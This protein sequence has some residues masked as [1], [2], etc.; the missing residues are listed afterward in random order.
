[1][2][3][4][5]LIIFFEALARN[6]AG[7]RASKK[8]DGRPG[9]IRM[10]KRLS[11]AMMGSAALIWASPAPVRAADAPAE[12]PGILEAVVITGT[13]IRAPNL[14]S[15][16]PITAVSDEEVKDQGATNIENVL[17]ELPQF[18]AGQS[19]T[20][21]NNS[22]GVAN[23]N[24]R[25]LGPTRTLVL[26]DGRR[27]GPGD[28]Q[29]A[30][31]AAADVNFIP[32]S[33]I[34]GVDVLTG[35]AS[36]VYGSD[37][38]AGVVNF[39]M[40]RDF[41]G[42]QITT[43]LNAAQHTQSG[44][45][46]PVLRAAPYPIPVAIPGNQFD[47]FV[48]DTTLLVGTNTADHRGNV[49]M[50]VE[51][52]TTSPV[53]DGSR[54]F[55][56]CA[57]S[58]NKAQTG[59][60]CNGSSNGLYGNF[61]TNDGQQL[62]L[63]PDGS[64][65][66]I[67]FAKK[68]KYSNTPSLYLQR[69]DQRASLG[70]I[71]HQQI[72]PALDVYGEVMFM[73]DKTAAQVAPGGL[74][75]GQGPTGFIQVPCNNQ[76]MS[77]AQAAVI[78]EDANGNPMPIYQAGGQPNI[79]TIL[80]PG[81]RI[82]GHPRVDNLE[83]TD[84][85]AVVGV[86]GDIDSSW[87]YDVSGTYWDSLLS[88][89]FLND[90][91]FPKVQNAINGCTAPGNPGCV[92]LNIFQYGGVTPAQVGYITTPGLKT[93]DTRET[94]IDGNV[95]GDFGA[96]G[97]TSPGAKNP[98]ATSFGATYRHDQLNFLPDNELQTNDLIGQGA[99]YP[100][101]SGAESVKEEYAELRVSLIEDKP[102][103]EAMD[104]DLAYRHSGYTVGGS[105]SGFSTN[106]FKIA[107]DY[108]PTSDIRFRASFNRAARAPN[109]YELFLPQTLNN[110]AGYDDPCS[111][112]AP[113]ATL[114]ACAKTGV[115]AAQYGNI[116]ACPS[117]NCDALS[118]GNSALKP[119]KADTYSFG[120]NFTPTFVPGFNASIDYWAVRVN[121]Y[122]TNLSGQQIVNGCLLQSQDALCSLIHRGPNIGNIF[123]TSG[124]VVETN[125]N[126][127]FLRNRGI[128]VEL[129]Y[130]KNLEDLGI[131]GMGTLVFRMSGTESLEQTVSAP[132]RYDCNGLY[133]ATCSAGGDSG[134]NFKWRHNARLT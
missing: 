56:G 75:S 103:V 22:T 78:C 114:A 99:F 86:R 112:A 26:I 45:L 47:G 20:T 121:D 80:M 113:K 128:D 72:N 57:V 58:L 81:L 30:Q 62:A 109:L 110:D 122:I 123:G 100:P 83:H 3:R 84:Y 27:L 71:G 63:N 64:A 43:T 82:A 36:A 104:L 54:D 8:N 68:L 95:S 42:V 16:S 101:V 65:T 119:E 91:S 17:N 69:E 15:E 61:N 40:I 132:T 2:A 24:L 31:G 67:P 35:G 13:R 44:T 134:P 107:A 77:A 14:A 98:V 7:L 51:Y 9:R 41:E 76:Y 60:F 11:I 74:A 25:G 94:T 37:A 130:R 53:L 89:K 1:M 12:Q 87:S 23:L 29:G 96:W 92:P 59:V 33:L 127:G 39:H 118:G 88:E 129:N 111:G 108:A 52:R 90:V 73:Q 48:G 46:D 120:F 106:T 18:H 97:G 116:P 28:P 19:N 131:H 50:Y 10:F 6:D 93:G 5:M 115:T 32:A 105:S 70:A 79:A 125:Q 117:T 85:R 55:E 66:F 34:S 126:I 102:F 124:W 4:F 38:I 49:T 133:G 21:S